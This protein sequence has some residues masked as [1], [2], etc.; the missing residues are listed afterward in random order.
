MS[1]PQPEAIGTTFRYMLAAVFNAGK[2]K[3]SLPLVR[4]LKAK[5]AEEVEPAIRSILGEL[6]SMLGEQVVV[7][8]HSD[9]GKEF[10]NT[11]MEKTV[12]VDACIPHLYWWI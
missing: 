8:L 5:A 1:G 10:V 7:R 11:S 2:G 12:A 6:N 3:K 4:G 9:A